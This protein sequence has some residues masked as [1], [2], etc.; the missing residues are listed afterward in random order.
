MAVP[1]GD[2]RAARPEV[3]D[4]GGPASPVP[5]HDEPHPADVA[6]D[7]ARRAVEGIGIADHSVGSD[8]P[9]GRHPLRGRGTMGPSPTD[10]E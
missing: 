2:H 10:R 1:V 3:A 7:A 6:E 5:T 9:P 8:L 4:G